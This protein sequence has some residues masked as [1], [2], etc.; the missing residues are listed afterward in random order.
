MDAGAAAQGGAN[1]GGSA[2]RARGVA[3]MVLCRWQS[4]GSL[5]SRFESVRGGTLVATGVVRQVRLLC[6]RLMQTMASSTVLL[7]DDDPD[8]CEVWSMM[9][10][11]EGF[12]PSSRH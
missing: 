12:T 7:I 3:A 8:I 2:E 1:N 9:L 11:M 6:R 10:E 4:R 5:A